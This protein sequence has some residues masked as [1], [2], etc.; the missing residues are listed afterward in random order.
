[1][2]DEKQ[3]R[4]GI[5]LL[6]RYGL[7]VKNRQWDTVPPDCYECCRFLSDVSTESSHITF[8]VRCT[9]VESQRTLPSCTQK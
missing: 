6:S 9:G 1:M 5:H 7:L 4:G 8:L 2:G 3:A